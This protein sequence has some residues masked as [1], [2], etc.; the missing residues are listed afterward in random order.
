MVIYMGNGEKHSRQS[1]LIVRY[2]TAAWYL[3]NL[4]QNTRL[5][6]EIA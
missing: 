2:G 1:G 4:D 3:R 6:N 5:L